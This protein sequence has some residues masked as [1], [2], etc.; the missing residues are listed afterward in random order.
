MT[1]KIERNECKK[2]CKPVVAAAVV[3]LHS[4][5]DSKAVISDDYRYNG[6]LHFLFAHVNFS[7]KTSMIR[8]QMF[9]KSCAI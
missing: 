2:G 1:Q 3:T 9:A 4:G 5:R 8:S 7:H 6:I